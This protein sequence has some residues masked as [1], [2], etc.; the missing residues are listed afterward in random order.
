MQQ[1]TRHLMHSCVMKTVCPLQEKIADVATGSMGEHVAETTFSADGSPM[2]VPVV[3]AATPVKASPSEVTRA[4][5]SLVVSTPASPEQDPFTMTDA[6]RVVAAAR[7]S[8]EARK[9]A[10]RAMMQS[11]K[12][13]DDDEVCLN[14]SA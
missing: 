13:E 6:E 8:A 3:T 11:G 5:H 4:F 12:L 9:A 1:Q 7:A 10:I 14:C 2:K